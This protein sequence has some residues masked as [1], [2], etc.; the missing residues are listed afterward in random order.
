MKGLT[1]IANC[2]KSCGLTD[3]IIMS[4]SLILAVGIEEI[5]CNGIPWQGSKK[6]R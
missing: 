6:S 3:N 5:F 2:L 4:K 1:E